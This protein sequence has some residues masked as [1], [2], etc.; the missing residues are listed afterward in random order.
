MDGKF[1]AI[2]ILMMIEEA[3]LYALSS[4]KVLEHAS[5]PYGPE[6]PKNRVAIWELS[7]TAVLSEVPKEASS[8]YLNKIIGDSC[9]EDFIDEFP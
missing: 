7:R 1:K 2:A 6:A 9:E 5:A 3:E 8:K 4:E